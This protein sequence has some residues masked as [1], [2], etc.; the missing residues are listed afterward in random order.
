[1]IALF[2]MDKVGAGLA[3]SRPMLDSYVLGLWVSELATKEQLD[4]FLKN[5]FTF[6]LKGVVPKLKDVSVFTSAI[7]PD[8]E[9]LI[10]EMNGFTHGNVSQLHWRSSLKGIAPHYSEELKVAML[11]TASIFA[12]LAAYEYQTLAGHTGLRDRMFAEANVRLGFAV[13]EASQD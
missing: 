2:A 12:L 13:A 1:M 11:R 4:K 5:Q 3:L 10:D 8:L 7:V 9:R 6:S